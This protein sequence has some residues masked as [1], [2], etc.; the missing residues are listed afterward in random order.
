MIMDCIKYHE[1]TAMSDS[2]LQ[3]CK[4]VHWIKLYLIVLLRDSKVKD[5]M[6]LLE[7]IGHSKVTISSIN[8]AKAIWYLYLKVVG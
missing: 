6:G 4:S 3:H 1:R 5:Y 8:R 2:R 7:G